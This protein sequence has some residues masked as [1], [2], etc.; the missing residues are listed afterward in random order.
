[1]LPQRNLKLYR[2]NDIFC[3]SRKKTFYNAFGFE[4]PIFD[5]SVKMLRKTSLAEVSNVQS[6]GIII[7]AKFDNFKLSSKIRES[8]Y[9]YKKMSTIAQFVVNT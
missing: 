7:N 6:P 3:I 4:S 5:E 8:G 2:S 1:M 9:F